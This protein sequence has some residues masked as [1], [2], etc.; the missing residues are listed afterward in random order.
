MR[1]IGMN[2]LFILII[3]Y[4]FIGIYKPLMKINP[5]PFLAVF[6]LF[7]SASFSQLVPQKRNDGDRYKISLKSGSFIPQKNIA[8]ARVTEMNKNVFKPKKKSFVIIQFE[9]IP[10]ATEK[11]QLKKEGIE[12]LEYVPNNAYTATVTG[13]LNMAALSRVKTRSIVELTPEQKMEPSL[14]NGIISSWAVKAEGTIDVWVS[15]PKTFSFQTVSTEIKAK[16]FD[17]VSTDYKSNNIIALRIATNRIKELAALPFIDYVQTAPKGDESLNFNST[18][19]SR[20]NTLSSSLPGGRNLKGEGIVVGVGDLINPWQ[21]IDFTGRIINRSYTTG[22]GPDDFHGVHVTGT[23]GGAGIIQEKHTGYA[24]KAKII[25]QVFSGILAYAPE[26][27]QDYGMVITNNS[28]GSPNGCPSFG[29]Y[30][31]ISRVVDQQAFQMPN[32]QHVFS[33]GNSGGSTC[34]PYVANYGN[35]LGGYQSSKNPICVGSNDFGNSSRGPVKDGRIKPEIVAQGNVFSTNNNLT[36]YRSSQG[37]SHSAPGVSGG[38]ALLYQRYKQLNSGSNPKS[39]LMKTLLCNGAIDIGNTGPDYRFGFGLMNLLR[40]VTML[41]KTNYFNSAVNSGATNTH[42]IT[43][44]GGSAIAQLKVMLYWNDSAAAALAATALVN[45]LDLQVTDPSAGVHFPQLLDTVPANVN[46]PATTGADHINNIEQVVINNPATGT[47]TFSVNGTTIPSGT[48][49]EYFLVFDTIPVSTTLTYPVGGEH[50]RSAEAINISWDSYGN[51]L[52][53][54]SLQYSVDN[55]ATWLPVVG[56]T[57]LAANL[58]QR[59]WTIPAVAA[60]SQAKVKVI[61]NGTGIE[62]ISEAFTIVGV[63]QI[64]L[65][66]VQCEGYISLTWPAIAGATDYEIMMLQGEE[67]VSVGTTTSLNYTISGLSKDSLYWVSL[68]SRVNGMPGRRDTAISIQPNTGTCAGTISDNDL[69]LDTILSPAKSGRKFTSTE[70]SATTTVTI[71]IENLDDAPTVGDIPVTYIVGANPPVTETIFAPNIAARGLYTY[72]FIIPVDLSAAGSYDLKVIVSYPGDPVAKNDTVQKAY[73]QLDNPLID[74]TTDFFDDIEG[75]A[76]QTYKSPQMGLQGLDRYDFVSSTTFGQLRTF[77]NS[78]IAYSGNKALTLDADRYNAGGTTDSLTA[79][80]NLQGYDAAVDDIRLSFVYKHHDQQFNAANKL[81]I[82]GDDQKPWEEVYDLFNNQGLA[83]VYKKVEGLEIGALLDLYSQNFS[84]SFQLRWGQWGQGLVTDNENAAGYTF[85]DIQLFKVS[86]DI[87]LVSIDTPVVASCGLNN[88]VPVKISVRNSASTT[89]FGIPVTF[90]IDN[91]TP[92]TETISSILQNATIS[93]TFTA[94]ANLSALGS[95]TVKVWVDLP[96]DTYRANDTAVVVLY[97]SPVVATFPYLQDFEAGDGSW[98]SAGKNN[99]W[100]YGT[101]ASPKINGAASGSKA[102]KTSL[103][104]SHNDLELSY[105]YSPCFDIT[106]MTKPMLSLSIA[107]DLED[108]GP[109]LCDAAYVEYSTDGNTWSKLGT[110]TTGTNWYN[111]NYTGNHVWSI[112]NYT[113]WHV[114]TIPL[115]TAL[116][117]LRLRFV[118]ESDPFVTNEGIAVDDIHIYDSVYGIYGGPPF[119][120]PVVTQVTVN[121]SNWINF[122]SAGK[123]I[124]S[125]NPN[126]QDMGSTDVQAYINTGAVRVNTFQY[127]HNR[128]I[129]IKPTTVNLTDSATVRFYFLDSET[130]ALINATGCSGCSKPATAY[131]LGVTKYS[132]ANDALENGSLADNTG[133]NYLFLTPANVKKVPFD[134]GYY[135]EF[136]VKDFS[137]FWLNNGGPGNIQPLPVDLISF[138]A[139]KN[140]NDDV[141]ANWATASENN[142]ARFEIELARGN[143]GLSQ[144]DFI[145]IGEVSSQGNSTTEQRYQ[146]TDVENNKAGVRYYRLKIVDHDGKFTYSI[147]R[148]VVFDA[149]IKWQVYPNPS[150][151]LFN[152]AYQVGAG[153]KVTIKVHDINGKLIKQVQSAANAFIQKTT[154]DLSGPQFAPGIYLLEV[155]TGEKKQVFRLLKR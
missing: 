67:M 36:G 63:P 76:I 69:K 25:T 38:L 111:K 86:N 54:F 11:E 33:A 44:P 99:S 105:L 13:S 129:T 8:D 148:A 10:T 153:E 112:Q 104:N 120:S 22:L 118:M 2:P 45:D 115:P 29:V 72:S 9:K 74:L 89:I 134:K 131:Q 149:E 135:A 12:L 20:S 108:C 5:V 77:V 47:Y 130:E 152:L 85:D 71:R 110:N 35:V 50:L 66:P 143:D 61:H 16:N 127:Y 14:A 28:Y 60:T 124:A 150:P 42:T 146:F 126:G 56:G 34:S 138:T 41:E 55:G 68:R 83:G 117:R 151:G 24:P 70:L 84:S 32:L 65:T 57:N 81:W 113:R 64:A 3:C 121:G 31:L 6:L 58:R 102:W 90:Q 59:A 39:G 132:D 26:Y 51:P 155:G 95:H 144:N 79:T 87:K 122:E 4:I 75:A 142:T 49:H 17:I 133:N 145:K 106:G 125:V 19:L 37:T 78:G 91:N 46:V 101:P 62:S 30:D 128:N 18:T 73:K 40:S 98:Y 43:I 154:I 82:R 27:V 53:T 114:A 80:F 96:A 93:Y 7:S 100:G 1:Q 141:V 109:A 147:I 88:T 48:N 136:K 116:D 21:H 103:T 92:V 52:N 94:T 137:E 15:F 23:V 97:N 107:L 119:T 140:E 123:L 139:N